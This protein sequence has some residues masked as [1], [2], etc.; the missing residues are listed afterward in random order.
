MPSP[1]LP[2]AVRFLF[3]PELDDER[4]SFRFVIRHKSPHLCLWLK[5]WAEEDLTTARPQLIEALTHAGHFIGALS[6]PA[7]SACLSQRRSDRKIVK[8]EKIDR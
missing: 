2:G 8:K 6:K 7:S 5:I 4:M 3:K 1:E